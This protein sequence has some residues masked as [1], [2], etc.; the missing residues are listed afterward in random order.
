MGVRVDA[1]SAA[2]LNPPPQPTPVKIK[3]PR[4][5]V[6]FDSDA[7]LSA[8]RQHP[9]DIEIIP[10]PPQQL[11]AGHVANDRDERVGDRAHQA[12]G[13][14]RAIEPELTVDAANDEIEAAQHV[15]RIVERALGQD[16]GFDALED[17]SGSTSAER[18]SAAPLG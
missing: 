18:R 2:E 3:P 12:L 4:V 14:F 16:V 6:Y 13:L 1:E 8:G 15:L 11:A 5:P 7:V 9:L 17:A 10:R